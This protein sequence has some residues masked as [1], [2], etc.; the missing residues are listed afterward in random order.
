[1]LLFFTFLSCSYPILFCLM[2]FNDNNRHPRFS[3]F[4]HKSNFI[5]PL[6]FLH[7]GGG[8][9]CRGKCSFWIIFRGRW[10]HLPNLPVPVN[11]SLPDN[12]RAFS[13]YGVESL[14]Y[15]KN[16]SNYIHLTESVWD[17]C[18]QFGFRNPFV[19]KS[20]LPQVIRRQQQRIRQRLF[21]TR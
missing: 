21:R 2:N 18:C 6:W 11:H 19:I 14:P 10:L 4:A 1:M 5:R 17:H 13:V 3:A 16:E 15:H 9:G 12:S 8:E 20:C 7:G